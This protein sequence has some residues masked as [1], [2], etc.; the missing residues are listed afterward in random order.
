MTSG[1]WQKIRVKEYQDFAAYF[2]LFIIG[3]TYRSIISSLMPS[4]FSISIFCS[5]LT[6]TTPNRLFHW[7]GTIRAEKSGDVQAHVVNDTVDYSRNVH[8][9]TFPE[10]LEENDIS[11][12]IYQNEIS[13]SKGMGGS[14]KLTCPISQIIQ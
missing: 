14:R 1:Y 2:R 11:W 4:P 6:G 10:M 13:L 7:T 8:W 9:K 3:T 5:S 12:R